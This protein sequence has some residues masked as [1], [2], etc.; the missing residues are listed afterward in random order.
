M[1]HLGMV[2][3]FRLSLH[4]PRLSI[5]WYVLRLFAYSRIHFRYTVSIVFH[6]N[7]EGPRWEEVI[8]VRFSFARN[9]LFNFVWFNYGS[10]CWFVNTVTRK[11]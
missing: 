6:G 10:K 4:L 5:T 11:R 3:T 8:D 2:Y 9:A 1:N 7:S